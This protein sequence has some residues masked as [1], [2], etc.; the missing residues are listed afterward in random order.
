MLSHADSCDPTG[1]ILP[2]SSV[3]GIFPT[4]LLEWVAVS[5]CRGSSWPKDLTLI[6]KV[7]CIAGWFFTAEP[8]GK[9]RGCTSQHLGPQFPNQGPNLHPCIGRWRLTHWTA[10]RF[11]F[12]WTWE[13]N[14]DIAPGLDSVMLILHNTYEF[15]LCAA[16]SW[17][18][19]QTWE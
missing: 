5:S 8:R 15:T 3:H 9:P 13:R 7:S 4:G 12:P 10:G 14:A 18:K 6:S 17:S 11:Q 19:L 2:G 16:V 1:C